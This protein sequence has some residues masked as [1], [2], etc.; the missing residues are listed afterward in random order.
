MFSFIAGLVTALSSYAIQPVVTLSGGIATPLGGQS[1]N[2]TFA[3]TTFNYQ[4]DNSSVVKPIFGGSIGL[5][6]ALN[7]SWIWQFGLGFY[8][9]ASNSVSGEEDQAPMLNPNAGNFWNYHYNVQS[10]QILFENKLF[11]TLPKEMYPYFFLGLGEGFNRTSGFEVTPQNSGEVATAVYGN[12][13]NEN[14]VYMTGLGLDKNISKHLRLGVGYR[15]GYLGKY[16]LGTGVLNTGAGGAVFS[17]PALTS[18]RS[19]S[20]EVLIQLTGLL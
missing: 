2:L 7:K 20:Q 1:Q 10:R 14:F 15:V 19:V 16:D 9:T 4:P 18:P 6:Y 8:Q 17:L 13:T 5:E 11:L 12:N 3:N